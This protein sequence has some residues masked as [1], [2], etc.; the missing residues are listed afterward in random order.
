MP[1]VQFK[2]ISVSWNQN[3]IV[4]QA[5][6][7]FLLL[8]DR[9][10]NSFKHFC[11]CF[12]DIRSGEIVEEDD[13]AELES[14]DIVEVIDLDELEGEEEMEEG[15]Q[16]DD[17]EEAG[18]SGVAEQLPEDNSELVFSKHGSKFC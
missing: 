9:S 12:P 15:D 17:E 5:F 18:S 1:E 10:D 11:I 3:H 16:E 8:N 6:Q 13:N 4:L 14:R 7:S 2:W